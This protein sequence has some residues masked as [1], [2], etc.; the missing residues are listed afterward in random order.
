MHPLREYNCNLLVKSW[1]GQL[2]AKE[3]LSDDQLDPPEATLTEA[4]A[5]EKSVSHIAAR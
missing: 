5:G 2:R 3:L 1:S 4:F